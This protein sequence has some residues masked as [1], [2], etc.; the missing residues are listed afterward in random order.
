MKLITATEAA[1]K[2]TKKVHD[3]WQLSGDIYIQFTDNTWMH[4][5]PEY[6]GDDAYDVVISDGE[7]EMHHKVILGLISWPE[8]N[9]YT[10]A[11]KEKNERRLLQQLKD[12]YESE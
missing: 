11:E 5:T 4:F 12:K 3:N 9:K 7:P 10:A 8:F 6:A 1:N 2:T